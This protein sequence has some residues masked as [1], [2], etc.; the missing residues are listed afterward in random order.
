ME[1]L[2]LKV[3]TGVK[4]LEIQSGDGG[5]QGVK[6]EQEGAEDRKDWQGYPMA[7]KHCNGRPSRNLKDECH[8]LKTD[9]L[10]V[11]AEVTPKL[12]ESNTRDSHVDDCPTYGKQIGAMLQEA[13]LCHSRV[14]Y[15]NNSQ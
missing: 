11:P 5:L 12:M 13:M 8:L 14:W 10:P 2:G 3:K 6:I 15:H 1:A 9:V 7:K 4:V